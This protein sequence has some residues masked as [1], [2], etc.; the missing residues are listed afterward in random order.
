MSLDGA[1]A[2]TLSNQAQ[3]KWWKGENV[4]K[5]AESGLH[6]FS[7]FPVIAVKRMAF[8]EPACAGYDCLANKG[9]LR[10]RI[11][12]P[13]V[14]QPINIV[15]THLN[16]TNTAGVPV[17]ETH[18]AHE[19]Q[20][21]RLADF[22]NTAAEPGLPAIIGGDFNI[23]GSHI[24]FLPIA[25]LF[26]GTTFVKNTCDVLGGSTKCHIDIRPDAPWLT[27]QD[28]QAFRSGRD[29]LV[30]PLDAHTVLDEPVNGKRLSAHFGYL[31]R[32]RLSWI[33]KT[34]TAD[35][36]DPVVR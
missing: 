15:T 1:T 30:T 34:L 16:S 14:P 22:W 26:Q 13:G 5:W 24:R 4:G 11:V 10:V 31:V 33:P 25:K 35:S 27:S 21:K 17:E 12:V 23:R 19:R 20:V 29:V 3:R 2:D 18:T 8:G 32:Y 36:G 6:I 7:A 28:M 9:A